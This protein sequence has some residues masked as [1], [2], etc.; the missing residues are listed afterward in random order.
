MSDK[1][2]WKYNKVGREAMLGDV[3]ALRK[4]LLRH[5]VRFTFSY[6]SGL[7]FFLLF[8]VYFLYFF[9][10]LL[11]TFFLASS[12]WFFREK[13]PSLSFPVGVSQVDTA[14]REKATIAVNF[15]LTQK[16]QRW[17]DWQLLL[18]DFNSKTMQVL[19]GRVA[20]YTSAGAAEVLD[21]D[22]YTSNGIVHVIDHVVW[23]LLEV[24]WS[25]LEG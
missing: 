18:V 10:G 21:T 1:I 14:S 13:L 5:I 24:V 12:S 25:L 15:F 23:S 16:S 11:F 6:F 2:N 17:T 9:S 7:R 19:L 4:A 20:I 8:Q 3:P 22:F